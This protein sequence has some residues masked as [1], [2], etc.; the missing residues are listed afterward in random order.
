MSYEIRDSEDVTTSRICF[1]QET[2]D[3]FEGLEDLTLSDYCGLGHL[4]DE[5]LD[6]VTDMDLVNEC[7][8][9]YI[10][11]YS[12]DE[13]V[14]YHALHSDDEKTFKAELRRKILEYTDTDKTA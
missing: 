13:G 2:W 7:M 9:C 12:E 4:H 14:V 3:V 1:I 6:H 10:V 5:L 8:N 11:Q